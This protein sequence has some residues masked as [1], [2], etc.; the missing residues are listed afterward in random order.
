MSAWRR[1]DAHRRPAAAVAGLVWAGGMYL[2]T[3]ELGVAVLCGLVF[4]AVFAAGVPKP[5]PA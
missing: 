2:V 4:A 1:L 5:P 3:R